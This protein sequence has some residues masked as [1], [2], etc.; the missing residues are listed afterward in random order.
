MNALTGTTNLKS[1]ESPV[2]PYATQ[3]SRD[4]YN[5]SSKSN[6]SSGK[7]QRHQPQSLFASK[8]LLA[9]RLNE[10][11]NGISV[12]TQQ[13]KYRQYDVGNLR[14][15]D[16]YI[17]NSLKFCKHPKYHYFFLNDPEF[18]YFFLNDL[19]FHYF[20]LNDSQ[21]SLLFS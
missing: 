5:S 21:I 19:K 4:I 17:A 16:I 6:N 11:E 7:S 1:A 3:S 14:K 10:H 9:P 18:H 2:S 8:V 13:F 20:F 12:K 15:C